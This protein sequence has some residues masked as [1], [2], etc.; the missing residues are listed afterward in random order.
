VSFDYGPNA[1]SVIAHLAAQGIFLREWRDPGYATFI[2][3]TIGLPQEN[4]RALAAVA[5]AA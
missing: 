1:A 5:T 2:R 3:M 4:D